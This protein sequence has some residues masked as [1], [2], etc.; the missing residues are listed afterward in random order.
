V[1]RP[2]LANRPALQRPRPPA[3]K[4]KPAKKRR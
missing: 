1:Q 2:G 3:P 4:G